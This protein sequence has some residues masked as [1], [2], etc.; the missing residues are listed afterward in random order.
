MIVQYHIICAKSIQNWKF[1]Q[2]WLVDLYPPR[3]VYRKTVN[4]YRKFQFIG[5]FNVTQYFVTIIGL[6]FQWLEFHIK[7]HGMAEK[8][9]ISS[10][11]KAGKRSLFSE[12]LAGISTL[13]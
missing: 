13:T 3:V 7:I 2:G 12:T 5:N 10:A 9:C 4:L 11:Q 1:C 8:Q 6:H